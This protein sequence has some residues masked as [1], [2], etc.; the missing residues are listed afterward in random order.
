MQFD[1]ILANT[2]QKKELLNAND[3]LHWRVEARLTAYLR[4]LARAEV[5]LDD[6]GRFSKAKPCQ[7]LVTVCSPTKRRLDPPNLYPTVK[8]LLD[9]FTDGG[10]WPD[11]NHEIVKR[12]SFA[13]G[14]LSGIDGKYEIKIKIEEL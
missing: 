6:R 14:G 1:F 9:G 13:Y 12:L 10:L 4:Q 8:A 7:V 2:R 11:D 3:R 5:A